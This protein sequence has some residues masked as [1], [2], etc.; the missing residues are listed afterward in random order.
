M[1]TFETDE[2]KLIPLTEAQVVV[3][4]KEPEKIIADLGVNNKT[5]FNPDVLQEINDKVV[6]PRLRAA[7]AEEAVFHTRW[8][9]V[10]KATNQ[11]VAELMVKQGPDATGA[12]E[13]GYGVYPEFAGQGWMTKIVAA[14]LQWAKQHPKVKLVWAETAKDNLSSIRVL[15]KN[16]FAK[17]RENSLFYYWRVSIEK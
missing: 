13:I 1:K 3:F 8:L 9:A 16:G 10:D 5:L 14:F 6:L 11:V 2:I 4:N 17:F 7:T 12:I 15:E